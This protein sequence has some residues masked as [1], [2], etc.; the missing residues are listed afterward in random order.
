[1]G[2]FFTDREFGQIAQTKKEMTVPVFNGI[3]STK[4]PIIF[5]L[6]LQVKAL[7]IRE[8]RTTRTLGTDISIREY[9]KNGG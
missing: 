5:P 8:R 9:V 1:M 2:G 6:F 3:V 7:C 4:R